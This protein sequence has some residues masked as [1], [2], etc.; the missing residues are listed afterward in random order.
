M[1]AGLVN[2]PLRRAY[3]ELLR[4]FFAGLMTNVEYE[5]RWWD[6]CKRHGVDDG[7]EGIFW[8]VDEYCSAFRTHR[9]TDPAYRPDAEGKAARLRCLLFLHSDAPFPRENRNSGPLWAF[10]VWTGML[11]IVVLAALG[12]QSHSQTV[13]G[14]SGFLLVAVTLILLVGMLVSVGWEVVREKLLRKS[15]P[16]SAEPISFWPFM[17]EAALE[18][19]RRRTILLG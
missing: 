11:A 16:A 19:V 18:A 5:D 13:A 7:A 14:L 17:S 8:A 3:A 2:I 10:G 12:A 9:M 1:E 15:Q 4:H 6:L